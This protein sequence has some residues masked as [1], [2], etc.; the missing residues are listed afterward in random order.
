[1]SPHKKLLALA[2]LLWTNILIAWLGCASLPEPDS[3][4]ARL[5]VRYCSG[6][7]CH[8]PILPQAGGRKYWDQQIER[9]IEFMRKGN[10]PLP[11]ADETRRIARYLHSHAQGSNSY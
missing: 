10:R 6:T 2:A 4:D 3:E 9:M 1:M 11:S 8:D 5:Y 7:G